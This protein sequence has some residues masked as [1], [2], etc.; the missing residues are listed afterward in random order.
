MIAGQAPYPWFPV[1]MM[2]RRVLLVV[3]R[4]YQVCISPLLGPHCRFEP[5][6]STYAAQALERHGLGRG[7]WRG[8]R[9]LARCNPLHPGGYDPVA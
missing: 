4:L 3:I 8:L 6:C 9:R 5:S 7:I 1:E 2:L